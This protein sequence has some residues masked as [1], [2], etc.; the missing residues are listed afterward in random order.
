MP[1]RQQHDVPLRVGIKQDMPGK[2][3]FAQ[4]GH[5]QLAGQL[6]R[7]LGLESP[8]TGPGIKKSR[9]A[10]ARG[11]ESQQCSSFDD[12]LLQLSEPP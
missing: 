6:H 1:Q 12:G 9:G 10:S 11:L 7:L 5:A 8:P 3:D 4:F 2:D